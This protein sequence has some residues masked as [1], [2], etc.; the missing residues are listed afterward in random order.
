MYS[1]SPTSCTYA[2][3]HLVQ[4]VLFLSYFV[5][6]CL[7]SPSA[8]CSLPLLLR[9]RMP[10]FTWCSMFS[11]S[12]TSC[13]YSSPHLVQ[14]V[15]FLSYFVYVCLASPSAVCSLPLLLRV[16]MPHFTWCSM[17][18]S[19]PTSCTYSS[20][21]L[22]QYVL[23]LSYFVYVCLASPSAVC[24]LPLLL[25]VRMPHFTWCS[26]FSSSP[27]SCTYAS[28]HLVQYVLF[29]SY[30]VYVCLASPSAV[31]ALPLLLRVRMPHLT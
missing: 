27:T 16:R 12:P 28:P 17:F 15:L 24:S 13:T 25:R 10:H 26:M 14:Y 3:P 31:C 5:Y 20:P 21:Q 9:V 4:Y 29:L 22:V 1:S 18:S 6:V 2:S 23:F 7:T 30:F 19:S 11:S 8:V